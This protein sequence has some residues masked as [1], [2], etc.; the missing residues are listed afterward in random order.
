MSEYDYR[1]PHCKTTYISFIR[2]DLE[3]GKVVFS[4]NCCDRRG[5]LFE[6]EDQE[7]GYLPNKV[8]ALKERYPPPRRRDIESDIFLQRRW[9]KTS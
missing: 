1:C 7:M 6:I 5:K 3:K 2:I 8:A 9:G 4:C